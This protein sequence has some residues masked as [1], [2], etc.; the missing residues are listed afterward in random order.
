M[1]KNVCLPFKEPGSRL[2]ATATA[3]VTGKRFVAISGDRQDDGTYSV[4]PPDAGG[5]VYGVA[6]YDAPAGGKVGIIKWP[7]IELPVESAGA[8]DAGAEVQVD[9]AGR[10]VTL[11]GGTPVGFTTTSN[12]DGDDARVVLY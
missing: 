7:G 5:R 9:G 8:I 3:A 4:A 12:A 10:V 2:T 6:E 11:A 1:A